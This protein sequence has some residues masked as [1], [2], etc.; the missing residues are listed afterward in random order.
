MTKTEKRE[1]A[2]DLLI[3]A[4][5]I[6]YYKLENSEYNHIT[7][8]EKEE[9]CKYMWQYGEAMAKRIDRKYYTQ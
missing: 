3:D 8:E 9:I 1:I 6:A 2:K 4:L 7:E 5:S